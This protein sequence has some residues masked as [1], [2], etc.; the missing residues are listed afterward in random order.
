MTV[1]D[2]DPQL[3]D[4]ELTVAERRLLR[5][6]A[7]G[8]LAD[9]RVGEPEQDDPAQGAAWEAGRTIRAGLLVSLLS[10]T[11][12]PDAVKPRAIRV[13]GARIAGPVDLEAATLDCPLLLQECNFEEPVNLNEAK[14]P[15][16]RLPGCHLP[17]L[18][19]EQLRTVGN[20][21]LSQGFTAHGEIRLGGAHIG[22]VL[23]LG[24]A[25]LINPDGRR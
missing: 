3:S 19:A 11:R 13:R 14:A 8:K 9:L 24:G 21:E 20:L 2:F 17:A 4:N 7:E 5:A 22:G 23:D 16:I 1:P 25:M 12:R 10:G 6:T 18:T 15:V